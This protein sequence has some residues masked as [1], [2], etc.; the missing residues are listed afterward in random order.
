MPTLRR[1]SDNQREKKA[2][3][4]K[5]AEILAAW[6]K[7]SAEEIATKKRSSQA[8]S[9]AAAET[10]L[11]IGSLTAPGRPDVDVKGMD[12][13]VLSKASDRQRAGQDAGRSD[14]AQDA[15]VHLPAGDRQERR[16]DHR[17]ALA[18]HQPETQLV[19]LVGPGF[20]RAFTRPP[21]SRTSREASSDRLS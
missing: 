1:V 14:H 4:G 11:A 12:V 10:S 15:G 21:A 20:S 7:L 19:S 13:D 6:N 3:T 17:G 18:H 8:R 5:D 9:K 16:S 2:I